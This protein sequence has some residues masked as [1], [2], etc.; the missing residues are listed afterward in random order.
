MCTINPYGIS[1]K[2]LCLKSGGDWYVY[3]ANYDNVANAFLT[4]FIISN[5]EGW[6]NNL[7]VWMDANDVDLGPKENSGATEAIVYFIIFIM[8]GQ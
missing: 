4:L 3:Q 2:E 1:T 8:I 5:G 7:L 6:P